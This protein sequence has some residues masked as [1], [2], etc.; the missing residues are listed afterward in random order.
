MGSSAARPARFPPVLP[1][2]SPC[3]RQHSM[4][5]ACS[6]SSPEAAAACWFLPPQEAQQAAQRE[7]QRLSY[8]QQKAD[9]ERCVAG[10]HI[11]VAHC[12]MQMAMPP[13]QQPACVQVLHIQMPCCMHSLH[14]TC[15]LSSVQAE[16]Q[17]SGHH[18]PAR[19]GGAHAAAQAL[20][21]GA[22]LG[23]FLGFGLTA[24]MQMGS[25]LRAYSQLRAPSHAHIL[26]LAAAAS[27]CAQE[28]ARVRV[29]TRHARGVRGT[30]EGAAAAALD[31]MMQ[32]LGL[33]P[34][35]QMLA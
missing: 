17:P 23:G 10:G 2:H 20:L 21:P 22:Q 9:R 30:S 32:R 13:A 15:R 3:G 18:R 12:R 27:C 4:R 25:Q 5:V 6:V 35:P 31:W 1:G 29:V 11:L 16:N 19:A 34:A 7:K 33:S 24:C 28:R 8:L 14:C 26:K